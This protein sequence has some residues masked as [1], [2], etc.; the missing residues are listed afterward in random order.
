MDIKTTASDGVTVVAIS[1]SLD[2][3]S[4][5]QAQ[6][7]IM[8]LIVPNGR[9]VLDMSAC[10]Y[11]SS[12]G[13]RVLLMIAKLL[14]SKKGQGVLAGVSAEVMDVMEMTGF[15]HFFDTHDT[16]ESAVQALREG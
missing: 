2:G 8:P 5:P 16:V 6:G 4:A 7:H 15:A 9:L 10:E 12:A 13:L 1:G 11:V 3:T 14:T